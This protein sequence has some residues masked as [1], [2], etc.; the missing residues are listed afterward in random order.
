M[1]RHKHLICETVLASYLVL[2]STNQTKENKGFFTILYYFVLVLF[3]G[4]SVC[5]LSCH[6]EIITKL[7]WTK[8]SISK[9]SALGI[10]SL[11]IALKMNPLHN[12]LGILKFN[13]IFQFKAAI[14]SYQTK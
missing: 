5:A 11:L 9:I 8:L 6:G 2:N 10:W 7:D 13:N 1:L 12:I 14:V 4:L 3:H